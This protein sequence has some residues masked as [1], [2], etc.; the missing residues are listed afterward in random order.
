MLINHC[1]T[2]SLSLHLTFLQ[3]MMLLHLNMNMRTRKMLESRF[4]GVL[5]CIQMCY[6]D[7]G[8][9]RHTFYQQLIYIYL[10]VIY[11]S[12]LEKD[13]WLVFKSPVLSIFVCLFGHNW[14]ASGLRNILE[15][16]NQQPDSLGLVW[17]SLWVVAT[18]PRL[19]FWK[20]SPQLSCIWR[21]CLDM[22]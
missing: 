9:S 13:L 10:W 3:V 21:P 22:V 1:S 7:S 12:L 11:W 17:N 6:C 2:L 16:S 18:S 20:T 8:A 19:V 14:S 4:S 5:E 15:P